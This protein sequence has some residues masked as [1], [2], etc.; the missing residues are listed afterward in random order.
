MSYSDEVRKARYGSSSGCPSHTQMHGT[1]PAKINNTSGE[2]KRRKALRKKAAEARQ[3]QRDK[4]TDAEQLALLDF[5]LGIGVG[6]KR[7]RA[8]L[9]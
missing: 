4:R 3:A 9:I 6:A 7:E 5:R 2:S 8:R 1:T